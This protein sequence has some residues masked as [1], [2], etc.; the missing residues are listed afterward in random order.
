MTQ[1]PELNTILK[2]K[3]KVSAGFFYIF[4]IFECVTEIDLGSELH[5]TM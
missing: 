3:N 4:M 1:T 5:V 2:G